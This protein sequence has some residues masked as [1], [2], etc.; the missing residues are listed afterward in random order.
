MLNYVKSDKKI[1]NL[2]FKSLKMCIFVYQKEVRKSRKSL[3]I[4]NI[5]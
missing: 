1:C 3:K 5:K 4:M 2:T